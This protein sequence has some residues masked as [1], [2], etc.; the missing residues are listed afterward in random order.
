MAKK[1]LRPP[2]TVPAGAPAGGAPLPALLALMLLLAPALGVPGE[3]MLQDTLK[4]AIVAFCA[5]AAALV[6][7]FQ[8]GGFP[9]AA[10]A[11][12]AGPAPAALAYAAGSMLWS[13]PY[14]GGV[15]AVRWFLFGL[16]AWLVLNTFTRERLP[17]LAWCIHGGAVL[18]SA[19]AVLQFWTGASPF[20][21]GPQPASTFVNRNFFAEF[22]VCTLP[23]GALLLARAHRPA[24]SQAW[25]RAWV[26][27]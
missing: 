6:F 4:S 12:P 19:W 24:W 26:S 3:E 9:A 25:R 22:V 27:C 18:A 13:H 23:F 2:A 5:L 11:W 21:Q 8:Q 7:L 17:L 1:R 15:E 20:P 16:I 10:L 14:L